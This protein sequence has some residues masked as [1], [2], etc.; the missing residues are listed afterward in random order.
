M[1]HVHRHQ[2]V[3]F[4]PAPATSFNTD[5]P[6][7][8]VVVGRPGPA[9]QRGVAQA[10]TAAAPQ[11]VVPSGNGVIDPA[12]PNTPSQVMIATY[13]VENLFDTV[14]DPKVDAD[15]GEFLPGG[16]NHWTEDKYK[17]KLDNIARVIR[18]VNGG[19]GPDILGLEE[20][21]NRKVL[22]DLVARLPDLGYQIIHFDSKDARG[23]DNAILARS[24]YQLVGQPSL[25]QVESNDPHDPVW[26]GKTTRGILEATFEVMGVPVTIF[27]NHWPSQGSGSAAVP[28]RMQAAQKLRELVS[29]HNAKDGKGEIVAVGDFNINPSDKSF[30][31]EGLQATGSVAKA[32][33]GAALVYETDADTF[34]RLAPHVPTEVFEDLTRYDELRNGELGRKIGTEYFSRDREWSILDMIFVNKAL[35]PGDKVGFAVVPGSTVRVANQFTAHSDGTPRRT[36]E[37]DGHESASDIGYSDH[38]M[39]VTRLE[40][41]EPKTA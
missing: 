5:K 12:A 21:E 29:A 27:V 19:R 28:R 6:D 8:P 40:K 39:K 17:A 34:Q 23:I 1:S 30:G 41:V 7:T 35:V 18:S 10:R 32:L 31:P 2:H 15:D 4:V 25:H 13:N 3:G 9:M 11:P 38:F 36:F 33:S 22:E 26:Q 20:I 37:N 24:N 16:R 14:H